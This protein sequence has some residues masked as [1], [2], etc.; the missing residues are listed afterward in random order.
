MT[1]QLQ[2]ESNGLGPPSKVTL[3]WLYEHVPWHLWAAAIGLLVASFWV[4]VEFSDLSLIRDIRGKPQLT[5]ETHQSIEGF[6]H[7][8]AIEPVTPHALVAGATVIVRSSGTLLRLSPSRDADG[9]DISAGVRLEVLK[10]DGE[11]LKVKTLKEP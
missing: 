3:A 7:F 2:D 6:V 8:S 4:G 9:S 11:W 10:V 5:I 1:R